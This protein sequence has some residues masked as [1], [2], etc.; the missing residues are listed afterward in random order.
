MSVI[1]GIVP[2]PRV[3]F[4]V[5]VEVPTG[6]TLARWAWGSRLELESSVFVDGYES[7]HPVLGRA[8]GIG[9]A[10][11]LDER[12]LSDHGLVH[13]ELDL[14]PDS[15]VPVDA[16]RRAA[17]RAFVEVVSRWAWGP[18][19]GPKLAAAALATPVGPIVS[20][21]PSLD[22]QLGAQDWEVTD[23]WLLTSVAPVTNADRI[24]WC[25]RCARVVYG[26]AGLL[27][28]WH[29]L[30]ESD[31]WSVDPGKSLVIPLPECRR[32]HSQMTRVVGH[33]GTAHA[34]RLVQDALQHHEWTQW[35]LTQRVESWE[36]RFF[37]TAGSGRFFEGLDPESLAAELDAVHRLLAQ[38]RRVCR[39]YERRGRLQ[40]LPNPE[41]DLADHAI[42]SPLVTGFSEEVRLR[43]GRIGD[44]VELLNA[45]L[46]EGWTLLAGA[47]GGAQVELQRKTQELQ[48]RFQN[49]AALI[50]ALVLVPGLVASLYSANVK[51]LP[52]LTQSSG[53]RDI[54]LYAGLGA[55]TTGTALWALERQK[56]R[57][58]YTSLIVGVVGVIALTLVLTRVRVSAI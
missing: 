49:A 22:R 45:S 21:P 44:R 41:I 24:P 14:H 26:P 30:A 55:M 15:D 57:I 54:G 5:R 18:G 28:V 38:L 12:Q 36:R 10:R 29:E 37:S 7:T 11:D 3:D 20:Q 50:T 31:G 40:W 8:I 47:A 6:K 19:L 9:A 17:R 13:V 34:A 51:G 32:R 23:L 48:Q 35:Q 4:D 16:H 52:G 33:S 46:R 58:A 2:S 25:L 42:S 43:A 1:G 53:L 39:D 27:A 56:R